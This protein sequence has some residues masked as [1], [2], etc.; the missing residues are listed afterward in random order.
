MI[1]VAK[2]SVLVFQSLR[3]SND[4]YHVEI[5][6]GIG[7]RIM[8]Y[9]PKDDNILF[10]NKSMHGHYAVYE[11]MDMEEMKQIRQNSSML[12]YGG[13]KSWIAPQSDWGNK[14]YVDLDHGNYE[15]ELV[16]SAER[17]EVR[18][19]SPICRETGLQITRII[20]ITDSDSVLHITQKLTTHS[21]VVQNRGIWQVTMVNRPGF[22]EIPWQVVESGP[23]FVDYYKKEPLPL[24][25]KNGNSRVNL[26]NGQK[27]K[28][29][30]TP[31]MGTVCTYLPFNEGAQWFVKSFELM[32]G[33]EYPHG[34]AVEVYNSD[35]FDYFEVEVHSPLFALMPKETC[36][37]KVRWTME[38]I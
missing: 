26:E 32:G 18:L 25:H 24:V 31:E 21:P 6:P 9:G 20:Q 34:V 10:Q 11:V 28:L 35:Q 13:E 37:F 19:I 16:H 4:I 14:P 12:L 38:K 7:G 33:M 36:E 15:V 2:S 30:Y 29:G 8:S 5:V 17:V 27:F 23:S 3:L 22:I 1:K